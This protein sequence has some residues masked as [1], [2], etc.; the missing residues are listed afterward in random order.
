MRQARP[1][2]RFAITQI[3]TRIV[4]A[5]SFSGKDIKLGNLYNKIF[6]FF[7]NHRRKMRYARSPVPRREASALPSSLLNWGYLYYFYLRMMDFEPW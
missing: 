1:D 3:A 5:R 2:V 7:E 4:E 6:N